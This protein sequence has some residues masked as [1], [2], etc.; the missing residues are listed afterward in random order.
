M[1]D[2][3]AVIFGV[4]L[5]LGCGVANLCMNPEQL[6]PRVNESPTDIDLKATEG[7]DVV[8]HCTAPYAVKWIKLYQKVRSVAEAGSES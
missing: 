3:T 2:S 7:S 6:P 1:V 4:C 5:L 8:L